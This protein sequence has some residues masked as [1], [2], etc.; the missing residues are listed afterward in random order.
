[1]PEDITALQLKIEE[2]KKVIDAIY[3]SI[4][5]MR[6]YFLITAWV[7]VIAIVFPLIGLFFI[8]P[9]FLSSYTST[10]QDSGN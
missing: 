3:D 9:S 2:Q 6:R 7:T 8:V 10:I 5:K 1:M 4:E